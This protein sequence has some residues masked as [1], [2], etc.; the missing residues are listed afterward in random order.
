[1]GTINYFTS[2]YITMAVEPCSVCDFDRTEAVDFLLENGYER[3][4]ITDAVID[5]YLSELVSVYAEDAFLNVKT[6]LEKHAFYYFD[7]CMKWGYYDG[8]QLMISLNRD[9]INVWQDKRDAQKEITEIKRFL[10]TCA[11]MGLVACYPSWVIS[12][13]EHSGTVKAISA[14]AKEMRQDVKNAQTDLQHW[15]AWR[16]KAV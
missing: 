2:D 16:D 11:D 13:E 15:R 9:R 7:I 12:Y 6:E 5:A 4:E 8:F 3:E 10:L 1:M 14:A